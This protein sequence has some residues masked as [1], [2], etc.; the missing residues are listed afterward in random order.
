ME[1]GLISVLL[2][3]T[4]NGE[5]PN[6]TIDYSNQRTLEDLLPSDKQSQ[7]KTEKITKYKVL[8]GDNL[9]K[10]AQKYNTNWKRLWDKNTQLKDPDNVEVGDLITI[11]DDNERIKERELPVEPVVINTA[12][13]PISTPST[14]TT[15]LKSAT[16]GN[17]Y[18]YGYCT[19]YVKNLRPDLPNNLGNANTWY[20]LAQAQGFAVGILPKVGAVAWTGGGLGHVAVVTAV[21]GDIV[22]ITEM[23]YKGWNIV[24]S[25]VAHAGE[26]LYI[27]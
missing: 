23:N 9:I 8:Q 1:Y 26:F 25:R 4:Q 20:Y 16:A 17:T 10:I 24:S 22:T 27:Y 2:Q 7:Q 6:L 21:N 11:P 19:W 14:A 5:V 13:Y 12:S 3:S 18:S 15:A